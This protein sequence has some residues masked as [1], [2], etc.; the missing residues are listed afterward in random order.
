MATTTKSESKAQA[1]SEET[2]ALRNPATEAVQVIARPAPG[3]VLV[4]ETE[5]SGRLA[6]G[7]TLQEA[8]VVALDVDLILTFPD[9]A[10]IILPNLGLSAVGAHPPHITFA[11]AQVAPET[12]VSLVSELRLAPL[13]PLLRASDD[14]PEG[15]A[16]KQEHTADSEGVP[17]A[18]IMRI[19]RH[20]GDGDSPVTPPQT[21]GAG[22]GL[23]R[24]EAPDT[25]VRLVTSGGVT[26]P[27]VAPR[28]GT[29][30]GKPHATLE[31][32]LL[33]FPDTVTKASATGPD[34]ILGATGGP[35][36]G[37][38]PAFAVQS[39][40]RMLA[41][42]AR[43][44]FIDVDSADLAGT[45]HS[46]RKLD[47]NFRL[48]AAGWTATS[49]TVSGLPDGYAITNA[50]QRGPGQYEI[51]LD[52][53][54][55]NHLALDLSYPIPADGAAPDANGFLARFSLAFA[56]Q[57]RSG[58][59]ETA[60]ATATQEVGVR[61]VNTESDASFTNPS[62]NEKMMVLWANP[63]GASLDAGDG[64]DTVLSGAGA[65]TLH[66][67]AGV[68]TLSYERSQSAV[69]VNLETRLAA[70]GF[71]R[72]DV[73]DGFENLTGSAYGDKLT[74]DAGGNVIV[75]GAGADT[76]DGGAGTDL[77]D[78]S[79]SAA[80]VTVDL[81]RTGAQSGGDAQGDVLTN[82]ENVTGS[83]RVANSLSGDANANVLT[84]GAGNDTLSGGLG[85]DTLVGAGGSDT[86]DYSY[87]ANALTVAL[88]SAGQ[89][90]VTVAAGSD[91]DLISGI[92]NLVGG[93]GADSLVG[94]SVANALSGGA[95]DDTL[96]GGSGADTLSGGS[97]TDLV[98][99]A[100]STEGVSVDLT[101]AGSQSGGDAA[102]DVLSGVENVTGSATGANWLKGDSGNNVLT[103]GAAAD[104]LIGGAGA[105]T[106]AGGAG[107]DLV[108]YSGSAAGVT[109]DLTSTGGQS[110]GDAQGDVLLGVENVLGSAAGANW[111][112]G[113]PGANMLAGGAGADTLVGG[114]GADT[115][116]GGAG[117]DTAD[118]RTSAAGVTVDLTAATQAGGDAQGD[119]LSGIERVYGATN[120]ANRIA[121]DASANDIYGGLLG[122]LL[123]GGAGDDSI[124]G[125]AGDDTLAGGAGAD[126]LIG[127]A[128]SDTAD[129]TASIAGV[130]VDLTAASQSG[131]D[132][133]GD[134]LNGI[135]NLIGSATSANRLTG[136]ANA[137]VLTGGAGNDTVIGGAGADTLAGGAGVDTVDYGSSA[138]GVTVNLASSAAQSGG[139]AAG[140]VLSGMENVVG[141]ATAANRLFGDR[142]GNI[143]TGGAGA[144]L[145]AAGDGAWTTGAAG[146]QALKASLGSDPFGTGAG[147]AY[148]VSFRFQT[149]DLQS[150]YGMVGILGAGGTD[151]NITVGLLN[152]QIRLGQ[153]NDELVA[154]PSSDIRDGAWHTI[155]ATMTSGLLGTIYVDGVAVGSRIFTGVYKDSAT[156]ELGINVMD[157]NGLVALTASYDD[158]ALYNRALSA[159]E[160]ASLA[161][162]GAATVPTGQIALYTF[163][164]PNALADAI[165]R[166]PSLTQTGSAGSIVNGSW[167]DAAN[168]LQGGAGA[169]TLIGG[170]GA[171]TL[172]GGAGDDILTGGAGADSILG[173]SGVDTASY[174]SSMRG[175]TVDLT[176][177]GAQSGGD[178]SGD[179]LSG[180]ENVVGSAIGANWLKGDGGA[181]VLTGGAGNDT[182]VGAAGADTLL[183]AGGVD[184][185]DYAGS[186]AGVT[187]DLR[188]ATSQSGGDAAG[189]ILSGIENVVGSATGASKL[190]GD[191]NAN[192]LTGGAGQD[193]LSGGA[194][195]DTLVGGAG[196]DTADYA[197]SSAGV[198]VDLGAASQTGGDAQGDVLVGIENVTGSATAAN[199]LKGDA[200][201]NVLTGGAGAD[202]LIGGAGADT[203]V[204]GAGIDTV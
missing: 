107:T 4:V 67:G 49:A 119:V 178:A 195:A 84:G 99:Y 57:I 89:V 47:I 52:A 179:V 161:S 145:L 132:A 150:P 155:T 10:K 153:T 114:A 85:N 98:D 117:I 134:R 78:Y 58:S 16:P 80:G 160:V 74:G 203:L 148:T 1:Q 123:S 75:G 50:V 23:T 51:L 162:N 26:T 100:S 139:D 194:G 64:A 55:P 34:T 28:P 14:R 109:V 97:G 202:T 53:K 54:D 79:A 32:N 125:G 95:G 151:G 22:L 44:E 115:M 90:T 29:D 116:T 154:S 173:G 184:T 181:N 174:L 24:A 82:I 198:S 103:G 110:G 101:R 163:D 137:N 35:G 104:T 200:T 172:D 31:F 65:D 9:G 30:E 144:D 88:N 190:T 7:F 201:A 102:G 138:A 177:A 86:V 36:S 146:S 189:D 171:D 40:P 27:P 81:Q 156:S 13:E 3:A 187:V 186:A 72:G 70:G 129:Y 124:D 126:T 71:A 63:P 17:P 128:G 6:F 43:A 176:S 191:A 20:E 188:L 41:A 8:T 166:N 183:G 15:E 147:K 122:D 59:G 25:L 182:L 42:T 204:G 45:A 68:D 158:V 140:D 175:V 113:D 142:N 168:L 157:G 76:I 196:V 199:W 185:A 61:F 118:Y 127:G 46:A 111:L 18:P 19:V 135:E 193:T 149:T 62:T 39:A 133:Q 21:A 37:E 106:L 83:A 143:L 93:S 197:A 11:G 66:G 165:G 33:N 167:S 87:T 56:L 192:V 92:E 5:R 108:D 60:L 120:D 152:G 159:A 169:D 130:T 170:S 2:G 96:I 164:G 48:P 121:G 105:D 136:D 91:V 77:A 131:G 141:S 69:T 112:K 38:N 73:I 180:V 12:L 94:D